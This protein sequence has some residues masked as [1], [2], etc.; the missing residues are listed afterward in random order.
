MSM[1]FRHIKVIEDSNKLLNKKIFIK[2][3]CVLV[4]PTDIQDA[5]FWERRLDKTNTPYVIIQAE[6]TIELNDHKLSD[7]KKYNG[8]KYARGYFILVEDLERE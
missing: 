8:T 2:E 1:K 5:E 6:T 4:G 7:N 3:K